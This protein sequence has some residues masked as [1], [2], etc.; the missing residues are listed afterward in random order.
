[1]SATDKETVTAEPKIVTSFKD[2]PVV[3]VKPNRFVLPVTVKSFTFTTLFPF[4]FTV[5]VAGYCDHDEPPID[6]T[7]VPFRF[8]TLF[9]LKLAI[10]KSVVAV[11]THEPTWE[12]LNNS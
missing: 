11:P 4:R 5:C 6:A 12:P 10:F 9:M 8:V 3:T 2:V 7:A 1:M